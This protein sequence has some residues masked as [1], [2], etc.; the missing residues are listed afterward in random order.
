MYEKN[1]VALHRLAR[2]NGNIVSIETITYLL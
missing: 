1:G 2:M